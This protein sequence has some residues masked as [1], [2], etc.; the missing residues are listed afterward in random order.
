MV[1]IDLWALGGVISWVI[2][3]Y[4]VKKMRGIG[5][6]RS[7]AISGWFSSFIGCHGLIRKGVINF[8]NTDDSLF[9][10]GIVAIIAVLMI[11]ASKDDP[12]VYNGPLGFLYYWIPRIGA[13]L[14]A[15]IAVLNLILI[16]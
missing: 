14:W 2:A 9:I 6:L 4:L 3:L 12:S 11:V 13:G 16:A 10:F 5:D 7:A 15:I 8:V 1:S